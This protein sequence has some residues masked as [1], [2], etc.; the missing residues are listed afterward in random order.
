MNRLLLVTTLVVGFV[1]GFAGGSAATCFAL[2]VEDNTDLPFAD[3]AE[4]LGRWT[5]VDFVEYPSQFDSEQRH[6]GGDLYLKELK[7][8]PAGEIVALLAG[9]SASSVFTWTKD[10]VINS[11]DK[12]AAKYEIKRIGDKEYLFL[13]WKSGDYTFLHMKPKYYVLKR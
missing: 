13:E 6:F 9:A 1:G 11:V 3:D 4:V 7:F 12:T 2:R 5:S 10:V 8:L